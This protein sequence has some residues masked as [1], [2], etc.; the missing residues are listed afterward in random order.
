MICVGFYVFILYKEL[1]SQY[2]NDLM[3]EAY[4][5]A[6]RV[7]RDIRDGMLLHGAEDTKKSLENIGYQAVVRKVR[8][9][10]SKGKIAASTDGSEVGRMIVVDDPFCKKCHSSVS[11]N[12]KWLSEA[13][14]KTECISVLDSGEKI[15]NVTIGIFNKPDCMTSEC[16]RHSQNEKTLGLV[17]VEITLQ[18]VRDRLASRMKKSI[19]FAL[20]LIG[21]LALVASWFTYKIIYMPLKQIIEVTKKVT[22]GDLDSAIPTRGN[23]DEISYLAYSFNKMIFRIRRMTDNLSELNA[24]L[25][26]NVEERTMELKKTQDSVIQSEKL[27]SLGLMAAAIAHE[28]NNPLTAVLTYSSLLHRQAEEASELKEDLEVIVSETSRCRDI[29]RGL[30]DFARETDVKQKSVNINSLLEETLTLLAH[31]VIFQNIKIDKVFAKYLPDLVMDADQ[32]KQVFLNI[33]INASDAMPNGGRLRIY[34]AF[35][36]ERNEIA[37]ELQDSGLGIPKRDLQKIFDPFFTTK[38]K[39]KGTGLGLSVV[40]GIIQRHY[41]TID[42]KS[43]VGKGTTFTMTFPIDSPIKESDRLI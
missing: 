20:I 26:K 14:K 9:L 29:V 34:T 3:S 7:S 38:E 13:K 40:Y 10:D 37:V 43:E 8:I 31:Q 6:S 33:M 42:V 15:A 4:E 11:D 27:A 24:E 23:R 5:I 12:R 30:L 28:I 39:G 16:H 21:G 17:D 41:G 19:V 25:E 2:E 36:Y 32:I 18:S 35:D 1:R 22:E